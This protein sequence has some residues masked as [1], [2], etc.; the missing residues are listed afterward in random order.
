[1]AAAI[2]RD[3]MR[4]V[5]LPLDD[6]N[7]PLLGEALATLSHDAEAAVIDMAGP[8]STDIVLAADLRY[9]GQS[10]ELTVPMAGSTSA[11][12][13]AAAFHAAHERSFGHAEAEAPV[14]V[15]SLR[16]T[17]ARPAPEIAM[18]HLPT[19]PHDA[20]VDGTVQLRIGGQ[21]HA[22]DLYRRSTL[23]PG[24]QFTGPAIVTQPDCTILVPPGWTARIDGLRNVEMERV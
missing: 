20:L 2:R 10:F 23:D 12:D 4:T 15:V 11:A 5:L 18:P 22:A 6:T 14:Q 19:P 17:A 1:V 8:G 13:L 7:W 9:R 3:T 24:A 21:T 16:A